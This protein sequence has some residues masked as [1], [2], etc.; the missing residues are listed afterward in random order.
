MNAIKKLECNVIKESKLYVIL[1]KHS[2]DSEQKDIKEAKNHY[3]LYELFKN[4]NPKYT[5]EIIPLKEAKL[6]VYSS[7]I[8]YSSKFNV[9]NPY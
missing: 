8:V 2:S 4:L 6:T 1:L 5:E 7:D 3:I 9:G